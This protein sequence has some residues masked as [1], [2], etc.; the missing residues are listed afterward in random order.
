L[1]RFFGKSLVVA[2]VALSLV[3]LSAAGLFVGHL[4]NLQS[5]DLGFRR[6]HV[7]LVTL[8]P[9]RSGYSRERLSGP[10]RELLGRLEAIPGVRSATISGATPISG[11]GA[12]RFATVEGHRERPEDRRYLSLN[13][14][15][16]KY[17]QT[18]GTPLLA[19]RDF[20]FEDQGRARVAIVNQAMARYYFAGG[21]PIGKHVTFDGENKPYEIVGMVGDAKYYEIR[22][23]APR[24]VYFNMFQEGRIASHFA[25]RTEIDPVAVAPEVR[26]TVSGLLKTIPV[27]RITTLA[28]Q[29]NASIVPERLIA[30]LSGL[31][32]GLGS[33][34][35]AIGLY[36]L[37]AYTV[38]RRINE[39]GIRMALG[40]TRS[41][42]TR[43]VLGEALG[44]V[45]AGLAV[46][47]P[48]AFWAKSFAANLIEDLPVQGISP[49]AFGAMAMLAVAL[50]AAY[51]PA[52]RAARVDPMEALRYE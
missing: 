14:V 8:D 6:D 26:R 18:L 19:G 2:Q 15:A 48:L 5:L 50:L 24:T 37:L 30:T 29:V 40:A 25:L 44:M 12:S 21:D 42:V 22:E 51:A 35:A 49:I 31:F 43:M 39:I 17:F 23:V 27:E 13:W 1:G 45:C 47:A 32:G 4:S 11:M 38:A 28:D 9:A 33:L 3:L 46:G 16:P 20:D 36:G 52:R 41:D 7:L 10:Y 34:L